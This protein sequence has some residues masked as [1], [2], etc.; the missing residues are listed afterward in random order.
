[1]KNRDKKTAI[2]FEQLRQL[3]SGNS[4]PLV[5]SAVLAGILA[6]MQRNVISSAVIINWFSLIA[7]IMFSRGIISF[8]Y[9]RASTDIKADTHR[10]LF[11]FRLGI[12][13]SGVAW[14]SSGFLLF[15]ANDPQNQ[16]FLLF[17]LA[18]LTSG[19]VTSY[20]ADFVSALVFSLLV[21]V[22]IIIR[23][24]LVGESVYMTMSIASILY[25]GHMLMSL[26]H[27][28]RNITEN[29]A[30]H[31]EATEREA[32]L[33][34]KAQELSTEITHRIQIETDLL[35][36]KEI[37]EEA[38]R[39]KSEF[40]AN[41]SHEIRTPMNGVLGML[42]LLSE[43]SMSQ[44]QLDWV[45]T[46]HSSGQA[47]LEIINDIL[48]LT[49]LEADKL[50]MEHVDFN[51]VDLVED[52]C[53]LSSN[54]AFSKGLELN[55]QLPTGMPLRWRGDP[56]RIRQ[57]LTNLI[58][59]AV[60]FTEQGEVT[61]SIIQSLAANN[62]DQLRFEIHD[63][64]IGISESTLSRLFEPFVQADSATSRRFG[65]SG[66]GLSI[67]KKLVELM[68]GTIGANSITGKGSCFW[69]SL[70]LTKSKLDDPNISP[71]S[72]DLSGKRV[73]IADDN[74]TNRSIL[75][76]YLNSWGLVVSEADSGSAALMQLQTSTLQ[77]IVYDLILLDM[78]MPG[79]DGLT[80]AKCLTQIPSLTLLPIILL[81]S[82][83]QIEPADYQGTGIIQRLFKPLRQMQLY[84]AIVTALKG[85]EQNTSLNNQTL[86]AETNLPNYQNK[87]VL[88]VEDNK[89]NQKV[90]VAKL[91]KYNIVPE[92]LENGLLAL[93]KL[94][95]CRYD[96]VF[97][98]C[99]MP[100]MDGYSATRELR[101][102]ESQ[103]NLPRQTVI[104]LTAN[105]L[106]GERD[107]CIA[108]GMDDYLTKP[109]V[110]GQL[111]T[112]LID[113]LGEKHH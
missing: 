25:L 48:D 47:L 60:K 27:I 62:T 11:R 49:K 36:A 37:A 32:T 28:N 108:A 71:T 92:V 6:F 26:R 57:V 64:G 42:D 14:G 50:E 70:P 100:V 23:L 38:T 5:S 12:L 44:A 33:N 55:C 51:L 17:I 78:Q 61:V 97:M 85:R 69:F 58:S 76:T 81:S 75:N 15:P 101:L 80:F 41:M 2:K 83:N 43:T 19:A 84:D 10:W 68:G 9:Q 34:R 77:G 103:Q 22:P 96:L 112:L 111:M 94:K 29:I 35:K 72:N 4:V 31:L 90:I 54:R 18:G 95:Q 30:L 13:A 107:K 91:K 73:L 40:L 59:N 98:D 79:M 88:V 93:D 46:A 45:K 39:I 3:Y 104:A 53:I 16:L 67:S 7:L 86:E 20:A 52:V 82:D 106:E 102:F 89:I 56:M 105:A 8:T 113:I 99:H 1:M 110:T 74:A 63:T 66:L 24:S 65:G 109:I 21:L 87:K